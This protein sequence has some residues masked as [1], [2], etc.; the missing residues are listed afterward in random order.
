[1][2][3]EKKKLNLKIIIPV[4]IIIAIVVISIIIVINNKDKS[5]IMSKEEMLTVAQDIT[6]SEGNET[7]NTNKFFLD[8]DKNKANA[9]MQKGNIYKMED[10]VHTIEKDYCEFSYG[11]VKVRLYLPT[12][13]LVHITQGNYI[14]V[15][16]QLT[17]I[18]KEETT[19]A[20]M[21]YDNSIYEFRNCYFIEQ[22]SKINAGS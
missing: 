13:T 3:K 12:E 9:E 17:N 21:T 6:G 2:E 5:E 7:P 15:V 4:V 8:L 20:G 22:N 10:Q 18:I 19:I 11:M 1:M 14:T 16:G